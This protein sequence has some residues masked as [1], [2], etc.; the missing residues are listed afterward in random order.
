VDNIIKSLS[1]N[2]ILVVWLVVAALT[3]FSH[4]RSGVRCIW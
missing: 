3:G 1:E 4:L 2:P